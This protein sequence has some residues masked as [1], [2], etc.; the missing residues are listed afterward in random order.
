M[1]ISWILNALSKDIAD[2]VIYSKTENELWDSLE[3]RF[4]RSNG[5]KLYHLQKELSGLVQGNNDIAGYFTKLKRL[6]DELDA[7]NVVICCSCVCTCEGKVKLTKSLEDQR[8]IQFLMGLNDIYAQARGNILMMNPLPSIDVAYSLILQDENQREVYAN[9][10]FNSDS[11]SFMAAGETKQ[12]NAQLLADFAAFMVIG[13][14]R[15]FQKNRNQ[16]QRG[17]ILGQKYNNSGQKFTNK[18]RSLRERRGH[19][20]EDCYRIIGFPDD[21]EFTNQ[22]NYQNQIKGNAVLAHEDHETQ[23]GQNA[24]NNN[25]FGQQLNKEKVAEMINMYKQA[26]LAQAGNSG[27][28][29]NSVAGTILKYSGSGLSMKSPQAFGE[30]RE[31]LYILEPSSLKSKGLFSSNVSSI[32]KGRNSTLE[33]MSFSSPVYV[34][35]IPDVKLWHWMTIVEEHGH[36]LLSSKSNAFLMLKFFLSMVERQFNVKVRM[37]RSDN[38]LELGKGT[39][40]ATFLALEGILHQL[41]CIATPQQNI[42]ERKHRHL[43]EI[44]RGLMFQSRMPMCY[45]GESILTA[46]HILNRLPS[47]VLQGKTPSEI[48]FQHKPKY[49]YLKIFGCLCYASI[50]AQGIGNFDERAT[51]CVL[52]GYLLQQ[53]GYKLLE[54]STR[55]V[56]VSRDVTFHESHFP[57]A[58]INIA[59]HTIFPSSTFTTEPTFQPHH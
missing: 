21:F 24:E 26:K 39:Q 3:Q 37:I 28:N 18:S 34:N 1:V 32:Q 52:L 49:D 53:K 46:T 7:L 6:W 14:G 9:A 31:G 59:H 17:A 27:I 38:A 47:S 44:D 35:A 48:L 54:L 58:E 22:K 55:K 50:L 13:Q 40:E 8:L 43:L 29:A 10:S 2:S 56:F 11:V 33:S 16:E 15:N 42:V 23:G 20:Q 25:N 19:A 51:S 45:W 41:S 5:A 36:F 57:F 12:P 30:V 4:G